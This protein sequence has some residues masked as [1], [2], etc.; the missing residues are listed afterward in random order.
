[1]PLH[2]WDVD[3]AEAIRIQNELRRK[4]VTRDTLKTPRLIAGVDISATRAAVVVLRWPELSLVEQEVAEEAPTFPYL[5][6]LLAFREIPAILKALAKVKSKPDLIMVD[7][8]GIAHPRRFGIAS[9]LGVLLDKPTI[10]C[11]KSRLCGKHKEPGPRKGDYELLLDGKETLGT[12]LR[13]R[14]ATNVVYVSVG[15]RIS[16][17]SAI[18]IVLASSKYR[19]PEPTRLADRL[20]RSGALPQSDAP[21]HKQSGAP[22]NPSPAHRR[23]GAR[24]R[25]AEEHKEACRF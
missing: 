5:P 1:M 19:I 23:G 20:S 13:T 24:R 7:G 15:H 22:W 17:K 9:H 25:D 12:A 8:Q 2:R 18:E 21:V 14:D 6:G 10:G 3:P 11:A 4:V 16:L